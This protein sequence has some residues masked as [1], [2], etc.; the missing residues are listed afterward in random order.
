MSKI[1]ILM[2]DDNV[3][4]IEM[5]R[6]YF[7]EH[8]RIELA[9]ESH[10][11]EDGLNKIL[12]SAGNYDVILLDLIMPVKDGLYVLEELKKR[13]I[14]KNI[15]VETSYNE[16]KIIRKV[17]EYGVNYYVLK[18]FNLSDLEDKILSVFDTQESKTINLYHSNLQISITKMLHELGMPSHIKGYQYIREG[19]TMIY[20]D[21]NIIG[22]ITK[23]LYPELASKFDTTV[24]RVE[25]AIRHAIEVSWNRGNWDYMEELFGH[26]VDIDKAKPTNSEFIVTVADKL[27]LE[28]SKQKVM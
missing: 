16:P 12:N 14:E 28:F 18:P 15:I 25:R 19:I 3:N 21:P 5:V 7:K 2:I 9:I 6:E 23:E 24:S 1:K 20:N 11:G 17:S 27:R 26:S 8:N 13:G 22:G 10:D 4:L